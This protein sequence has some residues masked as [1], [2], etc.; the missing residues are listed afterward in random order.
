MRSS[1]SLQGR[2]ALPTSAAKLENGLKSRAF[3]GRATTGAADRRRATAAARRISTG[4]VLLDV[5]LRIR[6]PHA[7]IGH[8][9]GVRTLQRSK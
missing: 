5:T 6:H 8:V 1:A 7:F 4:G 2:I 9:S 3:A